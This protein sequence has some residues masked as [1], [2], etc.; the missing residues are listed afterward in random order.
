M[1]IFPYNCEKSENGRTRLYLLVPEGSSFIGGRFFIVDKKGSV[2]QETVIESGNFASERYNLFLLQC[3]SSENAYS[4]G[5]EG[6][7]NRQ[8]KNT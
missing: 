6:I 7:R 5:K 8:L 4:I 3:D 1:S 2:H